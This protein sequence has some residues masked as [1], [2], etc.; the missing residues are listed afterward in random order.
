ML[1]A[2]RRTRHGLELGAVR[3]HRRG[4]H[5]DRQRRA[6]LRVRRADAAPSRR[7]PTSRRIDDDRAHVDRP[8]RADPRA[9]AAHAGV[10][11]P[12]MGV[13][14]RAIGGLVGSLLAVLSL[15][16]L[17]P[18]ALALLRRRRAARRSWCPFAGGL[19]VGLGLRR[20][21]A[22]ARPAARAR[23][24][25]GGGAGL[26]RR[27]RARRRAVHD[28]GR[29][30]LLAGRRLLRVH[31]RRHRHG[32]E[33]HAR[34]REPRARRSCFWRSLTQW[35]GGLGIIVL[36]LAVLPRLAVG[37]RQLMTREVPGPQFDKLAPRMRDTAKRF[38][39]LYAFFTG[40][41]ILALCGARAARPGARH[42]PL[43]RGLPRASPRSR[44]AASRPTRAPSSRSGPGRSGRSSSS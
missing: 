42:G 21:A 16:L 28:R 35:L 7:S 37:G 15:T 22:G 6:G 31:G 8:A 41:E 25:P 5:D 27:R 1:L 10:L 11:A 19:A 17:V 2:R 44:P 20:L 12:L 43:Q 36:V 30:R 24:L 33:Q 38:W 39:L 40:L 26:A 23:R 14:W 13:D 32:R 4:R 34:H 18:A 9:R 3:G 29:R